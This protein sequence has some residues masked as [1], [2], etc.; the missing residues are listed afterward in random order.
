[1][2]SAVFELK[3]RAKREAACIN[4]V[5]TIIFCA[6]ALLLGILFAINGING[7]LYDEFVL[8]ACA[9]PPFFMFLFFIIALMLLALS[10]SA[11][12]SSPVRPRKRGAYAMIMLY[13]SGF[14]LTYV[15]IPLTYKAAAFFASALVCAVNIAVLAVLYPAAK[16]ASRISALCVFIY[17]IWQA[18]LLYL[19]FSLFLVN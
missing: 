6:A 2:K 5:Q 4:T 13:V 11:A 3:R 8:P 19:S 14:A 1:M 16:R 15:W 17:A 9:L 10:A 7:E 18:Y 12:R